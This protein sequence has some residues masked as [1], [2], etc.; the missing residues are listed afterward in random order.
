MPRYL[1]TPQDLHSLSGEKMSFVGKTKMADLQMLSGADIV[2][3]QQS[4][5]NVYV[6][7][8]AD[9]KVF[10]RLI[11][12][13]SDHE[14]KAASTDNRG[15]GENFTK[16]NKQAHISSISFHELLDKGTYTLSFD[17]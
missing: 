6:E 1:R 2:L 10:A 9:V 15:T 7:L 16:N 13:S 14:V 17:V 8:P 5:L 4:L 11:S 12:E 3:T